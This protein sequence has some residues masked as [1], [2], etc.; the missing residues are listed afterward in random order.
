[1]KHFTLF[2]IYT[3]T[4]SALALLLFCTNYFFCNGPD[5][6]FDSVTIPLVRAMTV[7][8]LASVVFTTSM[9]LSVVYGILTGVGTIDRLKRKANDTWHTST[10]EPMELTE[11][12]GIDRC[13]V[14]PVDPIFEDYDK[15]M[16]YAT[17]QRLLRKDTQ[18]GQEQ[19]RTMEV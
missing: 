14:L 17:L 18:Y 6:E 3:W 8:C 16:G 7:L 10:D 19:H 2:L 4:A 15:V 11:I 9:L 12:F 5:C 13:W 1:M